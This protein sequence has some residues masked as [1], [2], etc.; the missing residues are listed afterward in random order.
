MTSYVNTD[1]KIA[2]DHKA[3]SVYHKWN[4]QW[5]RDHLQRDLVILHLISFYIV[6]ALFYPQSIFGRDQTAA[7]SGG[8]NDGGKL[9]KVG[10]DVTVV[11]PD[12]RIIDNSFI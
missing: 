4:T 12:N 8:L 10:A 5:M 6:S 2:L 3:E 1:F 9:K 11:E 7:S